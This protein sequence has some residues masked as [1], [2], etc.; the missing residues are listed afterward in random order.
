MFIFGTMK[1]LLF[2]ILLL[3]CLN[4]AHAEKVY[5]F[6]SLCQQAY[7]EITQLKL[8]NGLV[9]IEKAKQQNPDNLIPLVLESYID[10]FVLFLN[11]DPAE[12]KIRLPK[13]DERTAVLKQGPQS[14]PFYGFC[15]SAVY[16]HKAIIAIKFGETWSGGWDFRKAYQYIKENKKAF[17]TFAPN[18]LIYGSLQAVIG[19]IPKGYKWLTNLF[20]IKGSMNEGMK[21]VSG[22][23]NSN[24]PWAKLM[25]N[26]STFIYC[27]LLFYLE[28]KRDEAL[29]FLTNKK[30]DLVNN[31]LLAYMAANLN[32]NNKQTEYAKNIILNRNK[33]PEYFATEV[34][35]YEMGFARLHHLE[36]PESIEC[37]ER[38]INNFKGKFYVKDVY[39]KLSWCYYLQGNMAAAQNARNNVLKKGS[40]DAD[41]DKQALKEAKSGKWPNILLLKA[42]LL[43]DGGYNK[44]ALLLLNGKSAE[45]FPKEEEKLEFTYRLG[46]VYDDM[47][48]YNEAIQHYLFTIQS[49]ENSTEYYAARAA[50]QIGMIYE[51]KADK[52][53]AISF[54]KKCLDMDDHDYKNSL[55]QKAKSGIARCKGE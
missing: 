39:Q 55:D 21:L 27:Y 18:D 52:A 38:F 13:I 50:L 35:D 12:Y 24:D 22:F 9:L 40:T 53:Q 34:W 51:K 28:N 26:E 45:S 11:E 1:K 2:F 4:I 16:L 5:E 43:N 48:K 8:H 25:S 29:Q 41:A 6:N 36:V 10:F 42:R 20:G 14:S 49:G 37:L 33:S 46:R 15:L 31:H 47:G 54:Y 23:E 3:F 19:T 7:K 32:K 17:P 30:P 44:D